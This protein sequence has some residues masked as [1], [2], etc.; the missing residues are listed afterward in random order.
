MEKDDDK[1]LIIVAWSMYLMAFLLPILTPTTLIISIIKRILSKND[2]EKSHYNG[3]IYIPIIAHLFFFSGFFTIIY[4]YS[5]YDTSEPT[6]G[7]SIITIGVFLMLYGVVY[8]IYN[9]IKGILRASR[10][11]KFKSFK[12]KPHQ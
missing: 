3:L 5:N 11:E 1:N 10:M 9:S 4:G 6:I 2:Y 12:I 7:L 8:I